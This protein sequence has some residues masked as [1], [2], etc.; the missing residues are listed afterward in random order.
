MKAIFNKLV[1]LL[2]IG[3]GFFASC[4]EEA[5]QPETGFALHYP[6]ISEIAPG[7]LISMAPT[8]YGGTPT[9]FEIYSVTYEDNPVQTAC[10][11]VDAGTGQFRISGSS[12]LKTGLYK[13]SLKC[14]VGDASMT[15]ADIIQIEMMKPVPDGITV[16]PSELTVAIADVVSTGED[17]VLPEAR[18]VTDGNNH[19]EIDGYMISN[20]YLDGVVAN[21]YKTWFAI[22]EDGVFSIKPD[23]EDFKS[24]LYVFD[25]KLTTSAAEASSEE[26]IY[27]AALKL[28]VTSPPRSLTY[29]PD[30]MKVE[31]AAGCNSTIPS[32]VGSIEGMT[33]SIKS[34]APD[35]TVGITI[36]PQTGVL[37]FPADAATTIGSEY[38][39]SVSVEND[40]GSK[41]F[42]ALVKFIVIEYLNPV[43]KLAYDDVENHISG[44]SLMNEAVETD[45]DDVVYSFVGLSETLSMLNIDSAT[46]AVYVAKGTE[47]PIGHHTVTVR[48]ENMKGYVDATFAL[49]VIRNPNLFTYVC[50]GNNLG[51]NGTALTPIDK[52]G[53][54]FRIFHGSEPMNIDIRESDIPSGAKVTFKSIKPTDGNVTAPAIS[55]TGQL[56]LT[57]K[58]VGSDYA[59]GF[60]VIEV[61]VGEGEAAITKK[62]PVFVDFCDYYK[63]MLVSYTP[64]AIHVNPKTGGVSE[65]PVI[66]MKDGSDFKGSMEFTSNA[67]YFN[68]NGPASHE[69][70]KKLNQDP[71]S[72][73]HFVWDKYYTSIGS[74]SNY[75]AY[76][77]MSYWSNYSNGRLDYT[78]V[79][80]DNNDGMKIRVN[81]EKFKDT[82]GNYADG[83]MYAT[84]MVSVKGGGNPVNNTDRY[85][86]NRV[87]IWL[88]P[89]YT[90]N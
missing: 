36:N 56:T 49:G 1:F 76:A 60:S 27:P 48:A 23:N 19:L 84:M 44:V 7:T 10:F 47:I 46:G 8:W 45:G 53:N 79:Y 43:T 83:V 81:P 4:V 16:E 26:G 65:S 41:D 71:T 61:T 55:S 86:S 5:I 73:L 75:G 21:D 68:I 50:W 69:N 13:V 33:Y 40:Y 3:G 74:G 87:L 18:I 32:L 62:I 15:F 77:P 6:A 39:V 25:L 37:N 30:I 51:E 66:T 24:G 88:D 52:Y 29:S 9:D 14:K 38:E 54:Q 20:V 2:L 63:D 70:S 82:D 12:E 80:I 28:K 72:F 85:Q 35:N 42:D 90:E 89:N 57:A 59:L 64:F 11:T 58:S 78:G 67:A 17:M 22:S 34:V 31:I